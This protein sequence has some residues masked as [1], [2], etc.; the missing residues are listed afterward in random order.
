MLSIVLIRCGQTEYDCQGRIQGVLDVPLSVDGRHEAEAVA[1][2]LAGRQASL[3]A[4]YSGPCR[5]TQETADILGD[6]LDLKVKT[7]EG[8][9]NLNQGLWQGMLF[10]E[11]KSKQPKVYR[12]WLEKPESVRPPEGE[13]LQEARERLRTSM[14]KLAK[15][16][17]TGTVAL[18]LA[19][20]LFSVLR[21]MLHDGQSPIVCATEDETSPRW[22]QLEVPAPA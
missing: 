14:A 22:E 19:Q 4:I 20:P 5:S 8:L 16:H 9:H 10:D 18:V 1:A 6:K 21:A 12:Q 13:T 2:E 11:V 15:K 17:K 7:L 3:K